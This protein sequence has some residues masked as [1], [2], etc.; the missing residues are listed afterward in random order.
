[1]YI[2]LDFKS[3][4]PK[5]YQLSNDVWIPKSVLDSKGL[6]H[7]YYHIQDWWLNIQVE[8]I[9]LSEEDL[10]SLRNGKFNI[11]EKDTSLKVMMGLQPLLISINQIPSEI[12]NAWKKYWKGASDSFSYDSSDR[13]GEISEHDLGIYS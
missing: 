7:P 2:K 13:R 11:N 6:K 4:S 5:A 12:L 10:F 1:M 8:N 3:E 9:K